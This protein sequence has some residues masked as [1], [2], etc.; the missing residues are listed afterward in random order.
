MKK[1]LITGGSG[2]VGSFIVEESLR[3]GYETYVCV[4]KNSPR[5]YLEDPRIT[6]LSLDEGGIAS[7]VNACTKFDYVVHCAGVTK[8]K[9]KE[10][11]FRNNVE[12]TRALCEALKRSGKL[13]E[14]LMLVSSLAASG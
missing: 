8:A 12:F 9:R 6:L 1:V 13:P 7:I 5:V 14:K 10:A 3:R 11:Y 2:F 4:R